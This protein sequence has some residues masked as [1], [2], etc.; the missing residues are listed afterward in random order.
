[1]ND[2]LHLLLDRNTEETISDDERDELESLINFSE[3][4]SLFKGRALLFL[5]AFP[6]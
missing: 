3:V 2:R 5:K 4:M 1:M 6:D